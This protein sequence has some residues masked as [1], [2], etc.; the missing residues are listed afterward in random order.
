MSNELN[1]DQL[2][3][4][5]RKANAGPWKWDGRKVDEDGYVF[6]PECSYLVGGIALA[7]Q[8]EGYQDDCDFIAAFDP[9]TMLKLIT[10]AR[11]APAAAVDAE[12]QTQQS[13]VA[14]PV[15]A[16]VSQ[17]DANAVDA[18]Q[19]RELLACVMAE[20]PRQSNRN[21]GN[22][23]GHGHTTPG[24]WDDH[25]GELSGKECAWCKMW[26]AARS[27]LAARPELA[28]GAAREGG[29]TCNESALFA[30]SA[31]QEGK[32]ASGKGSA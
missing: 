22:A 28:A 8:H 2:E 16:P 3:A 27:A 32:Q 7:Y 13:Y 6:I 31:A 29:N 25:N 1:L 9:S 19:W 24:I 10:M 14:P 18:A 4:L 26:N 23:P 15:A 21:D 12:K 20:M 30:P 5:A 11:R 17:H